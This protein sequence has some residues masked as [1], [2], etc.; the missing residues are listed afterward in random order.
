MFVGDWWYCMSYTSSTA[1]GGGGSFKNRKPIGEVGCCESGMAER[2]HWWT[3][4]CL[5]SLTL[6]ISSSDYLPTY[7]SIFYVSIYLSIYLSI[8]ML[9]VA[10]LE[11]CCRVLSTCK[12]QRCTDQI[13]PRLQ[14]QAAI[15]LV[16]FGIVNHPLGSSVFSKEMVQM[17]G[18]RKGV[19]PSRY[20]NDIPFMEE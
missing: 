18:L 2:S 5:I 14:C 19:G 7:L 15:V 1:Q 13:S 17:K 6:S 9:C 12:T 10:S 20:P 8:R 11:G 16:C 4:R 3:E